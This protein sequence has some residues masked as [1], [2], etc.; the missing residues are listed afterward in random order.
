LAVSGPQ[1]MMEYL[2]KPE[3]TAETVVEIDGKR[4]LL[5]GDIGYMNERGTVV[6][7]DRKKEL[8]K[9]KGYSVFPKDVENLIAKNEHVAEVA[10]AGLPDKETNEAIKAWIALK[11]E[12]KGKVT[13]DYFM[14]WCKENLTHYKVPKY[15]EFKDEIPKNQVGK[16]LRRILVESDPVI[17]NLIEQDE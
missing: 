8:I 3:E 11:E 15:I 7:L 16:V 10:V 12:S 13:E 14:K 4:W 2:D 9:Y 17:K 6:I 5:T 1:V